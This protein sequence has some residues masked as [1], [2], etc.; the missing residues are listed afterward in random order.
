MLLI[1]QLNWIMKIFACQGGGR[2][3]SSLPMNQPASET[4]T[5][6]TRS[7][8]VTCYRNAS[9]WWV[10]YPAMRNGVAVRL[11]KRFSDHQLALH[12]LRE[13]VQ[14][15]EEHGIGLGSLPR[16][17]RS[18][19]GHYQ[20][21]LS[22]L[23]SKGLVLPA[24]DVL[25]MQA[26]DAVR[27]NL[28]PGD[29]SV[30]E[31]IERY[32]AARKPDLSR[33]AYLGI[34][35]RL[36]HFAREF[37]TRSIQSITPQMIEDWLEGLTR[38]CN[39]PE[40]GQKAGVA[41][42][43]PDSRNHYRAALITFFAHAFEHGWT[44]TNPAACVKRAEPDRP[45]SAVLTPEQAKTLLETASNNDPAVLPALA[46][47]MF[48]GLRVIEVPDISLGDLIHDNCDV[49]QVARHK[50]SPRKVPVSD[51]LR[52]WLQ[53]TSPTNTYAWTG[54][55]LQ[56]RKRLSNVFRAA[57]LDVS[58]DSPRISNYRYRLEISGDAAQIAKETCAPLSRMEVQPGA[59]KA[60]FSLA[61]NASDECPAGPTSPTS[62]NE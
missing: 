35:T 58:I 51:T 10:Y 53:F 23:G 33:P 48:A 44:S 34:R 1:S 39:G 13:K 2:V 49:I 19:Y 32:L 25:V 14:E 55:L 60:F 4:T 26:L 36:R 17:V 56:L 38:K 54:S 41:K 50:R 15:I 61:P 9:G 42:A 27:E 30:A 46:L 3:V 5:A 62:T 11:R 22:Q 7:G 8:R 29:S 24:F 6:H 52:E 59:A 31:C 21:L 45:K 47:Q 16:E 12:F 43:S 20:E 40:C 28:L 57:G 18:A 37:G